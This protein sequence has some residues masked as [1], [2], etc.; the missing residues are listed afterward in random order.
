MKNIA[1]YCHGFEERGFND[2]KLKHIGTVIEKTFDKASDC[3]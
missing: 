1:E 2:L 3:M